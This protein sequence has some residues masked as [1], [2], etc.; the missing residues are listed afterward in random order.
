MIHVLGDDKPE[1]VAVPADQQTCTKSSFCQSVRSLRELSG[2]PQVVSLHEYLIYALFRPIVN[3]HHFFHYL[4]DTPHHPSLHR[5]I[6]QLIELF[7]ACLI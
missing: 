2:F 4:S 1:A 7:H 5:L 3:R 6:H